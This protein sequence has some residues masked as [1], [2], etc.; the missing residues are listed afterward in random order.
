MEPYAICYLSLYFLVLGILCVYGMHRFLMTW[1]YR[2]HGGDAPPEPRRFEVLPF[3]T[4]QLPLYN[5]PRVVER[6]L[7]ATCAI[8]YPRDRFEIQ[9]LDDSTDETSRI[10]GRLLPEF[11]AKGITLRHI[12]RKTRTGFKAGAL[13]Q[14]L[15]MARGEF[16]LVFDAD[17]V[18]PSDILHRMIHHFT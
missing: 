13:A 6:L 8:D 3:V 16:L 9:V 10:V 7:R 5:E 12:R 15:E 18:P 11:A 4:I 2:R 17:F 1:L 14:G